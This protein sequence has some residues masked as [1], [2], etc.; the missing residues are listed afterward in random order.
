ML[1]EYFEI[2]IQSMGMIAIDLG[3]ALSNKNATSWTKATESVHAA[4]R[5]EQKS[6]HIHSNVRYFRIF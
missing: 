4:P 2:A 6:L 5:Y 3:P 1:L